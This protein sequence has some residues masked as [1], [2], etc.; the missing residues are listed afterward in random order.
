MP[1]PVVEPTPPWRELR[2]IVPLLAQD[3]SYLAASAR[4]ESFVPKSINMFEGTYHRPNQGS[5]NL[6]RVSVNHLD[7]ESL[8]Q[9]L[10][11]PGENPLDVGPDEQSVDQEIEKH[12]ITN[13]IVHHGSTVSFLKSMLVNP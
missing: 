11:P 8:A 1:V 4:I 7:S 6:S 2:L 13:M 9:L 10:F 12:G 3:A 5:N